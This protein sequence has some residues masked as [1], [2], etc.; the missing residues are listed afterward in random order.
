MR[1]QSPASVLPSEKQ[2]DK[3]TTQTTHRADSKHHT[4]QH[5]PLPQPPPPQKHR[6][7]PLTCSFQSQTP[8]PALLLLPKIPRDTKLPLA[9]VTSRP[10]HAPPRCHPR[11][12]QTAVQCLMPPTHTQSL[13]NQNRHT[14]LRSHTIFCS[15]TLTWSAAASPSQTSRQHAAP[16]LRGYVRH[17]Q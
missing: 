17:L 16:P 4:G 14:S 10:P 12:P 7:A 2:N 5:Q 3:T 9:P 6:P 15:Y 11:S 1:L 13:Q 8:R